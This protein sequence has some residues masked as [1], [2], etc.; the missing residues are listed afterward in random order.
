[1]RFTKLKRG[2]DEVTLV[3]TTTEGPGQ[4]DAH[5]HRLVSTDAPHPDLLA[6]FQGFVAPVLALCE[7]PTAYGVNL[8][9]SGVTVTEDATK[10]T[11]CVVTC[12]KP[13]VAAEAPL[14]FNSPHL[15][16]EGGLPQAML[17]AL[18]ALGQ[19]AQAFL[20]G[21]RAQGDLF[22][23]AQGDDRPT[24]TIEAAGQTVVLDGAAQDRLHRHLNLVNATAP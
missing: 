3:W 5:E 23:G 24:V 13:L 7:L 10:G 4:R 18:D 22:A 21:K 6:A 20:A 1:M 2:K 11:G 8:V 12:Q 14:I 15:T 17:R 16:E 19:E 9:V